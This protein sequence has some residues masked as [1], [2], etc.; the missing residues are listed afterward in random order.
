MH[1]DHIAVDRGGRCQLPSQDLRDD[2]KAEFVG[3]CQRPSQG[4]RVGSKALRVQPCQPHIRVRHGVTN[5]LVRRKN[6]TRAS[7]LE[8]R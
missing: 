7:R 2:S 1:N 5:A 4:C 3:R 8:R 6:H